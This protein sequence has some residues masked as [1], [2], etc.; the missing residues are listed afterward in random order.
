MS[1]VFNIKVGDTLPALQATLLATDGSPVPN[2]DSATVTFRMC[3]RKSDV[4]VV[5][6]EATVVDADT[7][8]VQYEWAAEDTAE[9]EP[10]DYEAEFIVTSTA[11][12]QTVPSKDFIKV[13]VNARA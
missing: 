13:R 10:G 8:D 1:H 12:T 6:A 3:R 7:G 9:L 4:A 2:L 5:E 11:G